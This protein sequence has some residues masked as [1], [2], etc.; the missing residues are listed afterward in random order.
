MGGAWEAYL[1]RNCKLYTLLGYDLLGS[2]RS[3][4]FVDS[5]SPSSNRKGTRRAS[6]CFLSTLAHLLLVNSCLPN[7]EPTK[8]VARKQT[9][10]QFDGSFMRQIVDGLLGIY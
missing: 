7:I 1:Q 2:V 3:L 10:V 5:L 6:S 4:V 8:P 9:I